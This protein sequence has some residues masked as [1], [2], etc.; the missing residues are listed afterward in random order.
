MSNQLTKADVARKRAAKNPYSLMSSLKNGGPIVWLSCLIMGFGNIVAG[1]F[2]KGLIFLAIEILAICLMVVPILADTKKVAYTGIEWIQKL[3]SLGD[4]PNMKYY[5]EDEMVYVTQYGDDSKII[6]L[7]GVIFIFIALALL[8]VWRA[9]VRSGYMAL[10]KRRSGKK[11]NTFIQDVKDLFDINIHKLLMMFP[12]CCLVV[13]TFIPLVYMIS[14][15]FTNFHE[16]GYNVSV[17]VNGVLEEH[18]SNYSQLFDWVGLDTFKELFT[19]TSTI[20]KQFWSVLGWTLIW[21]FFA[22][23]S[24]FFLGTFVAMIINRPTTQLKGFWRTV[25]SITIAVPQFVSLMLIS[26]MF[27]DGGIINKILMQSGLTEEVIRFRGTAMS[28]RIF[29]ILINIWV[30]IPHTVMQVTGILKNIPADLYEAAR[31]DGAN[32]VQQFRHITLPYMIFVMTPYIITS[33]TG[34]INNFNVIF[35]LTGGEPK[36]I[37][38]SAGKTDLLVTWLYKL[39]TDRD[40]HYNIAAVIGIFTFIILSIVSLVTYRSSGSYKDEEGFK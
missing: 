38:D 13:F 28:A 31:I 30:G 16:E 19:S 26:K 32:A 1:Q 14:M 15:A 5:D 7:Y 17:M 2:I 6:L 20:S 9:S 37:G 3:P 29:V 36:A 23:F 24:N 33:F 27:D 18:P 21:A 40:A 25:L 22:T 4:T 8:V 11:P 34:N 39:T 12:F 35:L 10:D